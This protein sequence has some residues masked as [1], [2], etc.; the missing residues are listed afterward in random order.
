MKENKDKIPASP[1]EPSKKQYKTLKKAIESA[2]SDKDP[3]KNI[4]ALTQASH[5]D[6]GK[7]L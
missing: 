2:D 1:A 3:R 6:G 4:E 5:K 7:P